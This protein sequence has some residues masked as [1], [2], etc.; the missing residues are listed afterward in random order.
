[1]AGTCALLVDCV[2]QRLPTA[3]YW[4]VLVVLAM[5]SF[6]TFRSDIIRELG[7]WFFST[8][9]LWLALAWW[10]HGGWLRA[11]AIQLAV[12]AAALFRLEAIMLSGALTFWL[13]PGL[14]CRAGWLRLLQLN[15]L[16][17]LCGILALGVLAGMSGASQ[18]R[19]GHYLMLLDPR[20]I[21]GL[22]TSFPAS[23][24]AASRPSIQET[25]RV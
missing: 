9:A 2:Q 12:I 4:A 6:N 23:S 8:L 5:P 13:L 1:M 20:Q 16:P 17:L 24:L 15:A 25:M 19:V 11:L 18:G 21:V 14:G 7:F 3:G 22:F 10:T